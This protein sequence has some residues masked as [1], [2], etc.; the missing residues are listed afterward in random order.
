MEIRSS[1]QDAKKNIPI[2][3]VK[4]IQAY[5]SGRQSRVIIENDKSP[6][7]NLKNG[8]P[9]GGVLSPTL[10]SIYIDDIVRDLDSGIDCSLFADD[11]A[12]WCQEDTPNQCREKIQSAL[13]V[14]EKWTKKWRMKLNEDKT[15]YILFSNWNRDSKW[16]GHIT[17]NGKTIRKNPNSKFLGVTFDWNL[18]FKSHVE[19]IKMTLRNRI[20]AMKAVANTNWGCK[21][22]DLRSLYIGFLRSSIEYAAAGWINNISDTNLQALEIEQ[23]KASRVITGCFKSTNIDKLT[24]EANLIPI[25]E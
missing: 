25:S 6:Y 14:I 19:N 2:C 13:H 21:K 11:L 8:V 15:E 10:F 12:I 5:L 9:Q 1:V 7:I 24:I 18:S 23:N 20:N 4:W 17:I 3:F 22:D 16:E